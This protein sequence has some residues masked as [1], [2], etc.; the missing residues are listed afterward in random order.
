M[1]TINYR[2]YHIRNNKKNQFGGVTCYVSYVKG[3]KT[4]LLSTSVCSDSDQ[5][6]RH[7]GV[8]N[9]MDR[10]ELKHYILVPVKAGAK[11]SENSIRDTLNQMF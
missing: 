9:A 8:T 2:I 10:Y 7:F 1:N 3:A 11:A 6:I 4:F 5:Y